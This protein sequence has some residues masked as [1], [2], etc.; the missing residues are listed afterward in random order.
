MVGAAA[1]SLMAVIS[2]M[3][4]WKVLIGVAAIVLAVSLPS[5]VLTWFKLRRRD[6]CPVLNACGWAVN[7]QMKFSMRLARTF[8]KVSGF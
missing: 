1:A 2:S 8:T 6:L 3:V 7:R 4:W 5:V